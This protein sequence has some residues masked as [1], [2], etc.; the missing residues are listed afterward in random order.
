[1]IRKDLREEIDAKLAKIRE[2]PISYSRRSQLVFDNL[3]GLGDVYSFWIENPELRSQL[4][5]NKQPATLKRMAYNGIRDIQN[6]WHYLLQTGQGGNFH[7]LVSL[8]VLAGTN[9]LVNGKSVIDG[10]Y[11]VPSKTSS[12][13]VTLNFHDYTPPSGDKVIHETKRV[14]GLINSNAGGQLLDT[15]IYAH[16]A[17]ALTQPFF[18]GNKRTARLVQDRILFEAG[19]PPAIIPASEGKFYRSL[20]EKTAAKYKQNDPEGQRLFC[21]YIAS[22]VNHGLDL[23]LEDLFSVVPSPKTMNH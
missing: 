1:M 10:Q 2:N 18:D 3:R 15:A 13:D 4:F 9:A 12:G 17:I 8:D 16:L 20:L 21:E 19:L 5:S 22:K 6:A 14:L 23:I 11:R 7:E